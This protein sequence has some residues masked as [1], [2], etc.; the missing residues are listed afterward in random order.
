MATCAYSEAVRNDVMKHLAGP[1]LWNFAVHTVG[2]GELSPESEQN[3]T[4]IA[5][6]RRGTFR[7]VNVA[8]S[9]AK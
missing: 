3:L 1:Q 9:P 2:M 4:A 5:K 8:K 7:R 6:A